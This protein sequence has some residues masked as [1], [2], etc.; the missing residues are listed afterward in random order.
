MDGNEDLVAV[1]LA[2]GQ[3]TRMRSDR[4]KVLHEICGRPMIRYVVDA[5]RSVSPDRIIIVV[6]HQ[7]ESVIEE[8]KGE[9]VEFAVQKERLGTGHAVLMA[10]PMLQDYEGTMM[11][12][13][14]DTPLLTPGTLID[15]VRRHRETGA[16]G[17]V[18]SAVLEDASGYGRIIKDADGSFL[19]IVEHKDADEAERAVNEIN[20]GIFCFRAVD[21]FDA[22]QRVGNENKQGEYYLTDVMS[23]LRGDGKKTV[24]QECRDN[25]EV[26][27]IND[28]NQLKEAERA[29]EGNG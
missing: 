14:G 11:V 27:G 1:I 25:R 15:L 6:G 4:A 19:R 9:G 2:A 5:A 29:I 22:L 21:L 24:V 17:T 16:S 10:K 8:M 3:G 18:L 12:L 23:I 20:S 13:T 26:M 28:I 7:A